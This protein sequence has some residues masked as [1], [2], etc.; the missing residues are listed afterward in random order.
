MNKTQNTNTP[1]PE[2]IQEFNAYRNSIV[3]ERLAVLNHAKQNFSE[4]AEKLSEAQEL[5]NNSLLFTYNDYS[6]LNSSNTL[7][8]NDQFM[9]AE[10][11]PAGNADA[12]VDFL[13]SNLPNLTKAIIFLNAHLFNLEL[14]KDERAELTDHMKTLS[15]YRTNLISALTDQ[16]KMSDFDVLQNGNGTIPTVMN[17]TLDDLLVIMYEFLSRLDSWQQ[18]AEELND[19][20]LSDELSSAY[21]QLERQITDLRRKNQPVEESERNKIRILM[22]HYSQLASD[23]FGTAL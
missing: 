10:L 3:A 13:K 21:D 4:S 1:P 7:T 5:Y 18:M 15:N 2:Q 22:K 12:D 19:E 20:E 17:S 14:S 9:N 11:F 16:E 23:R 8:L 6:R